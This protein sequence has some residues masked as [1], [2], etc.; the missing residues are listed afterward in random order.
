[1]TQS[2]IHSIFPTP[3]YFS[4]LNREFSKEELLFVN[5]TKNKVYSN[6]SNVTSLDTYILNNSSFENL[7]KDCELRIQDYF[8]KII[9][10]TDKVQP[11]ITQSWLN[12]TEKNQYHQKH[13]HCN[14]L[15]SGVLYI[16]CKEENDT[17]KFFNEKYQTIK[18][19][20]NNYNLWNS[21]TWTFAVKT[22]DLILFPSHLT[23]MVETKQTEHTRI[24]LA[25]NVFIKG[26]LGN[27]FTLTE[28]F[29]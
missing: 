11:Y 9:V 24:S 4:N 15:L 5:K 22:G 20:V 3:V 6:E 8:D 28:L 25:F 17:I 23:H 2:V 19:N 13:S 1:M 27:K 18:L 7:K 10:P 21:E 12:Y 16:D 14:S 26:E 29:V